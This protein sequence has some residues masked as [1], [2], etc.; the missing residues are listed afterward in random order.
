MMYDPC[1]MVDERVLIF[2]LRIVLGQYI[3][4]NLSKIC[5]DPHH[6]DP[7]TGI[8]QTKISGIRRLYY[9]TEVTFPS[10]LGIKEK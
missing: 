3:Y 4:S 2:K 9:V 6:P 10:Q 8:K 7:Q 5:F 1:N